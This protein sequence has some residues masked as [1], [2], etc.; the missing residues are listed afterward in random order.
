MTIEELHRGIR[1]W[2][3]EKPEWP[4]DFHNSYYQTLPPADGVFDSQWWD[5]FYPILRE[6]VATRPHSRAALTTEAR[7]RFAALQQTWSDV[8][9]KHVNDDIADV[10]WRE[11][12]AFPE[13]VSQIKRL[14]YPSP[15]FTAKFCA[16]LVP[17]IFPITDNEAVQNRYT[18]YEECYKRARG[19]W[20]ETDANVRNDLAELLRREIG[21]PFPGF[22]MKCKLIELCR[23]GRVQ[24]AGSE[25][26]R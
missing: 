24:Q 17:R 26:D 20:L 18:T 23:I 14:K 10:E 7:A 8:I 5:R 22:P 25:R 16:L 9:A 1:Y 13:L 2:W 19:E 12:A 11:I 15:V 6:W 4:R 21:A 3:D